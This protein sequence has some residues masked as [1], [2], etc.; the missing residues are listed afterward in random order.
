MDGNLNPILATNG[1]SASAAGGVMTPK[2]GMMNK[3]GTMNNVENGTAT[4]ETISPLITS[5]SPSMANSSTVL[6][7]NASTQAI[8][9]ATNATVPL[10]SNPPPPVV[11]KV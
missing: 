5:L 11:T 2:L 3:M 1:T 9:N 6:T 7:G 10:I 8:P 4:H